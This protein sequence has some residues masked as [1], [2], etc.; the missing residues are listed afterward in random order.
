ME[1]TQDLSS[2]SKDSRVL[3]DLTCHSNALMVRQGLTNPSSA[4]MPHIDLTNHNTVLMGLRDLTSQG[5]ALT[6]LQDLTIQDSVLINHV[7][8]NSPDL[9]SP[10]GTL[11]PH[12]VL[13]T[14]LSLSKINSKLQKTLNRLQNHPSVWILRRLESLLVN[15]CQTKE[16]ASQSQTIRPKLRT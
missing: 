9:S 8:V 10:Q 3:Q 7:S 16:R 2:R 14:Q 4:S 6:V 12:I 1:T 11:P 13:N 15:C 5:H